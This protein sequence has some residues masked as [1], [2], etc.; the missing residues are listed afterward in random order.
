MLDP[1]ESVRCGAL[2]ALQH[3]PVEMM[4]KEV[5]RLLVLK[6]R[7]KAAKVR[8]AAFLVIV[9]LGAKHASSILS[10]QELDSATTHFAQIDPLNPACDIPGG[11]QFI[12]DMGKVKRMLQ[13]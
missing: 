5:Y 10:A 11:E 6:C 7:D 1:N 4:G 13:W 9:G 8:R 2:T 3:R 12:K